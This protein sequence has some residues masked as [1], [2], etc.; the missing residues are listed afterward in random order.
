MGAGYELRAQRKDGS[1]FL[2]EISLSPLQTEEGLLITSV[3]R[4]ITE[5]HQAAEALRQAHDELEL[6]VQ[7]RTA[8]LEKA[9]LE[10]Q[11]VQEQLLRA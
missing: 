4:D 10:K 5:R 1:E 2:V 8:D 11:H 7:E 9:N 3:I 6:R